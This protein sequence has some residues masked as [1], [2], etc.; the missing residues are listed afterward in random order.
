M[1]KTNDENILTA[2]RCLI[3]ADGI[4]EITREPIFSQVLIGSTTPPQYITTR[5]TITATQREKATTPINLK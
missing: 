1:S 3:D 2:I 4:L 5:I